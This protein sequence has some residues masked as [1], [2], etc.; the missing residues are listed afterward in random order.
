MYET[1]INSCIEMCLGIASR[2]A[3]Q[4]LIWFEEYRKR[5]QISSMQKLDQEIF[6]R[7]YGKN[8]SVHER[9]RIRFWRLSQHLPRNREECVRLGHALEL[10]GHELDCFFT[11]GLCSQRLSPVENREQMIEELFLQYLCRI[12]CERLDRLNVKPGRQRRYL[13]HIFYA[14]AIDCLDVEVS[15]RKNFYKEHHYSQIFAGEFRKYFEKD[16]IISRENMLRLLILLLMP[17]VDAGAMDAW[18]IRLGYAPL[19][20]ERAM[21]GYVD[22]A[23]RCMLGLAAGEPSVGT[24][25]DKERMK[26]ILRNYDSEV[27]AR[28]ARERRNGNSPVLQY[29]KNLRFMKFRSMDND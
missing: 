1:E 3:Q 9:Q 4:N 6:F 21:N 2:Q 11:E 16:M 29:L 22:C 18:L 24:R 10:S 5:H 7:M 14:D 8:P 19:N 17:D 25:E 20:Q 13:R 23:I 27:K 12:S 26:E 15:M 28:I